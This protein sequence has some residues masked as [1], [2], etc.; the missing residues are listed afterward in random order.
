MYS[1]EKPPVR[2]WRRGLLFVGGMSAII[3]RRYSPF[4][5]H[6]ETG[7]RCPVPVIA[8][9]R[10][11]C[12]RARDRRAM[13]RIVCRLQILLRRFYRQI[14]AIL[15]FR[16]A[17]YR[18]KRFLARGVRT[19]GRIDEHDE[20]MVIRLFCVL[21]SR[22]LSPRSLKNMMR[23]T[24]SLFDDRNTSIS[25]MGAFLVSDF[26]DDL[27]RVALDIVEDDL[28]IGRECHASY[29][30]VIAA[31]GFHVARWFYAQ[32]LVADED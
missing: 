14:R 4:D 15:R 26:S 11:C 29:V 9:R 23:V 18:P 25:T 27:H 3:I 21:R 19:S 22:F 24:S 10:Q 12:L 31:Q 6:R 1:S 17:R 16:P 5:K 7:V 8:G 13:P 2:L 32:I 30:L 28:A 20:S